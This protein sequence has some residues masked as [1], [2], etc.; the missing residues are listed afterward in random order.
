MNKSTPDDLAV[1]FRS[2]ARR[3]KEA[4]GDADASTVGGTIGELH[5]HVAS[6]AAVLGVPADATAVADA[7]DDRPLDAWDD[8]TLDALRQHALDAGGI[9]RRLSAMTGADD[10]DD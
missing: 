10:S 6:A 4:I 9:L 3:Q 1:T 5:Q 7:I 8:D 2:L